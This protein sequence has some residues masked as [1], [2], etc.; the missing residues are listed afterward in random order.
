MSATA[1]P[2]FHLQF[3]AC[4]SNRNISNRNARDH[5]PGIAC[6]NP[7]ISRR[8]FMSVVSQHFDKQ[9]LAL[10]GRRFVQMA[11]SH[12]RFFLFAPS[13]AH[14]RGAACLGR[15]W[16]CPQYIREGT[17]A[18]SGTILRPLRH[19]ATA[20]ALR[21]C[22]TNN[23]SAARL[24]RRNHR[25]VCRFRVFNLGCWQTIQPAIWFPVIA[26]YFQAAAKQ[27]RFG[28]KHSFL[29]TYAHE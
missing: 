20:D 15:S 14:W 11:G 22:V 7:A 4:S 27:T 5:D 3:H 28:K 18:T 25:P 16:R 17:A 21:I 12:R 26:V 8:R 24:L 9:R 2:M 10:T 23:R 6:A 29:R 1:C 13:A 19:C